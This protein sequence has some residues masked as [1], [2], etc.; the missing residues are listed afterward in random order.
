MVSNAGIPMRYEHSV[1]VP[2]MYVFAQISFAASMVLSISSCFKKRISTTSSQLPGIAFATVPPFITP[3]LMVLPFERS[4]RA[5]RS[6]IL[7]AISA[8][9]FLPLA[10]SL[11]A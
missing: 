1:V 5:S 9:A 2:S 7:C 8:I 4:V 6:R 11:P 3:Q 10:K